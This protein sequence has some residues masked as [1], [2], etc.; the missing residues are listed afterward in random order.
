MRT[1]RSHYVKRTAPHVGSGNISQ[2]DPYTL[3]EQHAGKYV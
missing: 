2:G 3:L 1:D